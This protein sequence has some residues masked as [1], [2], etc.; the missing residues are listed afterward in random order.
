MQLTATDKIIFTYTYT[1]SE[2]MV[3]KGSKEAVR[4]RR[5]SALGRL[6]RPASG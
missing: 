6:R 2:T 3:R 4:A 5:A 1:D